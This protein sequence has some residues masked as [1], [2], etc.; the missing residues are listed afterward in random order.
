MDEKIRVIVASGEIAKHFDRLNDNY[1]RYLE[2]LEPKNLNDD[3]PSGKRPPESSEQDTDEATF[4]KQ[5][6]H[7][8]YKR[9][10]NKEFSKLIIVADPETLGE[11]RP[12]LHEEVK[13]CLVAEIPK[14]L[15]NAPTD[16]IAR[17]IEAS[18]DN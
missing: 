9:A 8:L 2:D 18:F 3:G 16:E 14:T 10:Y 11:L 12:V 6:A 4:A 5:L 15:I 13:A 7:D 17:V 1:Y